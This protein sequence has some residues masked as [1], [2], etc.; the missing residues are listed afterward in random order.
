MKKACGVFMLAATASILSGQ[1]FTSE[2]AAASGGPVPKQL[3]VIEST[4]ADYSVLQNTITIN[5]QYFG[6]GIPVVVIN[7]ISLQTISTTDTRV[8]AFLPLNLSPWSYE[9]KLTNSINSQ[10]GNFTTTLGSVGPGGP[11]G[12]QGLTG[13]AGVQG[14][15]GP[16]GVQGPD[17]SS[18]STRP[19]GSSGSTRADWSGGGSG[20]DWCARS[21]RYHLG[22]IRYEQRHDIAVKRC[23]RH[24]ADECGHCSREIHDRC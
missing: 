5:G 6:T 24:D 20:T 7:G 12:P 13:P 22:P 23:G 4:T 19:D 11:I 2:R 3:P 18:G 9:L 14:L 1:G 17:G 21:R 8:S 10:T 15:T 16:A